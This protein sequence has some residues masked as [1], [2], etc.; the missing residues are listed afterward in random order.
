M[1]KVIRMGWHDGTSNYEGGWYVEVLDRDAEGQLRTVED[2]Q[3]VWF[4]VELSDYQEHHADELEASLL[5]AYPGA[6]IKRS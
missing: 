6:E 4:P 2:S 3:K 1:A 5:Q